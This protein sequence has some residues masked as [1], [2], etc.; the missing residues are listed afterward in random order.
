M[1]RLVKQLAKWREMSVRVAVMLLMPKV[2]RMYQTAMDK[3]PKRAKSSAMVSSISSVAA[4]PTPP[5]VK[6]LNNH[7]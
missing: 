7:L 4:R 1:K 6:R 5:P 2:S 3:A